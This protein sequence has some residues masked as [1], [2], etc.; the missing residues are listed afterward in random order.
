MTELQADRPPGEGFPMLEGVPF[1]VEDHGKGAIIYM[2]GDVALAVYRIVSGCVRLQING[3]D[4]ERHIVSFLFPGELFGFSHEERHM[5]AEAVTPVRLARYSTAAVVRLNGHT[6]AFL[7]DLMGE[8]DERLA[9][10]AEH[11]VAVSRL[12]APERLLWFFHWIASRHV[13]EGVRDQ[14]V[15]LP[16]SWRE[17]ADFLSLKHETLSRALR[18]L[19]EKGQVVREGRRRIRLSRRQY[20]LSASTEGSAVKPG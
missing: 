1:L 13:G 5:A 14:S 10:L 18:E 11:S 12:P 9:E 19:A 16:M 8:V 2:E 7:L 17:V 3:E 20:G 15:E 4:G 6:R